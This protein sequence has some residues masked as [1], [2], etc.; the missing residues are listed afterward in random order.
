V[1]LVRYILT[2]TTVVYLFNMPIVA[3]Y[4]TLD[5]TRNF[6]RDTSYTLESAAA[7]IHKKFPNVKL[8]ME[9]LPANVVEYANL[10]YTSYCGRDLHLDLFV[11]VSNEGQM[12]PAVLLIHGGGWSSGD[13]SMLIPMAEQIAGRGYVTAAVEY[14]LSPEALYP[15][16]IYDLKTAVRWMRANATKYKIDSTKIAV[17]GCSAGGELAAFLGSTNGVEMFDGEGDYLSHS[18]EVEAVID[19]DGLLDFTNANS[20]K[21]D[22][23]PDMPSAAHK[24]FGVSYKENPDLWKKASPITYVSKKT[25]PTLFINSSMSH[26]HAGQDEMVR[27]LR[28]FNISYE[29]RK[30]PGTPHTF[31]LFHPWFDKTLEYA[32]Q[33]LDRTLKGDHSEGRQ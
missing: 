14:R 27:R 6:P 4:Q 12:H 33:F 11:P 28:S 29:V 9:D 25:P 7:K 22:L 1:K 20:V 15:A 2:S 8:A 21:Y 24:W 17:Y 23:N 10:S 26:Y 3:E 30:L 16:A 31:W 13:K 32:V 19:V 5:S 18:D